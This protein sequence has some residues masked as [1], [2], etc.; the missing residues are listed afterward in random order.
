MKCESDACQESRSS[1]DEVE[2]RGAATNE[3]DLSQSSIPLL[4][5][6]KTRPRDRSNGLL[7]VVSRFRNVEKRACNDTAFFLVRYVLKRCDSEDVGVAMLLGFT[8]G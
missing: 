6:L 1:N 4:G 8:G 7:G 2:R 3:A 5:S